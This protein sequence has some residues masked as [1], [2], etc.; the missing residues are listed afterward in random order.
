[1][2][3]RL[4]S[5]TLDGLPG[6][7]RPPFLPVDKLYVPPHYREDARISKILPFGEA[8]PVKL[9]LNFEAFNLTN[10]I[11]FTSETF[12]AYTATKNVLT[13]TPAAFGVGNGDGGFP[14]G[15]EARRL[16]FSVRVMF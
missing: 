7:G 14:D 11:S 3:E 6:N 4:S 13:P 8:H 9:Y 10:T 15:T 12:Q 2:S 1:V 5:S 16:Q